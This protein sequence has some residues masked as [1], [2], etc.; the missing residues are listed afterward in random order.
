M[1]NSSLISFA[2]RLRH[3]AHPWFTLAHHRVDPC[4][5]VSRT[6][7]YLDRSSQSVQAFPLLSLFHD[8]YHVVTAAKPARVLDHYQKEEAMASACLQENMS[9]PAGI[10]SLGRK[11]KSS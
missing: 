3:L 1:H 2:M 6:P 4:I 11:Q 5:N 9:L 7:R 8:S 10:N